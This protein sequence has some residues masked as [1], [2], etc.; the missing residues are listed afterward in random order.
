MSIEQKD[1]LLSP[2]AFEFKHKRA[3][4][5]ATMTLGCKTNQYETDAIVALFH[6]AAFE[7]VSFSD[8]ADVYIVNTCTVTHVGDKKSRQMIRR[9]KKNNPHALIVVMGCYAQISTDEVKAL[10]DVD[11]VIGTNARGKILEYIENF[12]K[13]QTEKPYVVVEDIMAVTTFE[14][15]ALGTSLKHTRAFIK[16][17]EG[18]NQYCSYCIIPYARGKVRSR[19]LQNVVQEVE[20]LLKSGYREF[21]LTG[22]HIGSYGVDLE[23]TSLIDLIEA[24]DELPS[25]SRIRLGSIEPRLMTQTF[26]ER[27][28]KTKHICP[29][30]HLS[31]QSGSE[32]VL[33]KMNRKYSKAEFSNAVSRLRTHFNNPSITTDVIVGFPGESDEM[34]E[35]TLAFVKEIAFSE[36]HVFPFSK[37]EGTPAASMPNQLP[38][39]VKKQRS[40]VLMQIAEALKERYLNGFL[41]DSLQVL[42]EEKQEAIYLGHTPNY[43]T[44][45]VESEKPL[46]VGGVYEV[47][48]ISIKDGKIF[49]RF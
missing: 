6:G 29:H 43:L 48:A 45:A 22:I 10:P 18:C 35:E 7:T 5:L 17:Q 12:V 8:D 4:R 20:E 46:E 42:I 28:A 49:A 15:L 24:L 36:M 30:F 21:V 14:D 26:V 11:I 2:D 25:M 37:R 1:L 16:I 31:L 40:D 33:K 44:V 38:L 19:S 32:W 47:R 41:S 9:A 23:N 39:E 3:K 34:F 13:G 27:L